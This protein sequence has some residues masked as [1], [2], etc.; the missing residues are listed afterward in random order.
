ADS[1]PLLVMVTDPGLTSP[2]RMLVPVTMATPLLLLVICSVPAVK[3]FDGL[4][5][6]ASKKP[7]V[8]GTAMA[9]TAERPAAVTAAA[10]S[11]PRPGASTPRIRLKIIPL[12]SVVAAPGPFLRA[13]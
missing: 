11:R 7:R 4:V 1:E 13:A 2:G 3:L 10:T 9:V 12:P 8:C 5:V 6:L